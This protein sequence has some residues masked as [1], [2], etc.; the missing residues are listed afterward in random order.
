ML[1]QNAPFLG[2]VGRF[3]EF[4]AKKTGPFRLDFESPANI[5]MDSLT[6]VE[7]GGTKEDIR[8]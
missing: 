8:G 7:P 3:L 2:L 1:D 6:R 5:L 4:Q